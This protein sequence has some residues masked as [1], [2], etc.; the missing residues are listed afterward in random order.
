MVSHSFAVAFDLNAVGTITILNTVGGSAIADQIPA[1]IVSHGGNGF[2]AWLP[3]GS[4]MPGSPD[5]DESANNMAGTEFVSKTP[6]ETFDDL[7][8]WISPAVLMNR[9]VAAGRL[10]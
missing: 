2:H 5:G 6:T 4:R 7:V 3:S 8:A 10:P 9:M 1:V